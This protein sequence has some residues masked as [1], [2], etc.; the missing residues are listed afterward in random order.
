MNTRPEDRG[1]EDPGQQP[2]PLLL[3]PGL[4]ADARLYWHQIGLLSAERSVQVARLGALETVTEMAAAVLAN[5]P[6]RFAIAGH[7]LGALVAIS[8]AS[9]ARERISRLALLDLDPLPER[10]YAAADREPRLVRARAGQL[11]QCVLEE[12]PESTLAPGEGARAVQAMMLEM[13]EAQGVETYVAQARALV[14]R[15]DSQR[16]LRALR[17][18]TLIL[19]GAHDTICPVRRHEFLAEVMPEAKLEILPDAG[20]L[21]TLEQPETVTEMLAGWLAWKPR[22]R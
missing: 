18:P 15:P 16:L 8:V 11:A 17:L 14:R 19:C 20:H 1:G 22:R 12:F 10:P 2:E 9:Q 21:P 4:M 13:A 3:V 7:G 5:A 6:P